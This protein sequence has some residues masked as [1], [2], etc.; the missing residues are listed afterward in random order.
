MKINLIL[1][2]VISM[3]NSCVNTQNTNPNIKM[4]E[5]LQTTLGLLN[6]QGKTPLFDKIE[7]GRDF[8][9]ITRCYDDGSIFFLNADP[10]K[11]TELQW[12]KLGHVSATNAQF[13]V[14]IINK[15]DRKEKKQFDKTNIIW[16]FYTID[17]EIFAT[18]IKAV[19]PDIFKIQKLIDQGLITIEEE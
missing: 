18:P 4:N 3:F 7:L 10:Q 16:K 17:L 19:F 6:H 11:D 8:T 2:C 1:F 5:L 15:I 13:I 9:I 14:N 12:V